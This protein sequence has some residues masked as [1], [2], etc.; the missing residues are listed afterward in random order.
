[1]GPAQTVSMEK[2]NISKWLD[3]NKLEIHITDVLKKENLLKVKAYC[4]QRTWKTE[5]P[6]G[7]NLILMQTASSKKG[8]AVLCNQRDDNLRR[9]IRQY[10]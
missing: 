10:T 1:M 3:K 7:D 4:L 6:K 8:R 2:V 9:T 5:L